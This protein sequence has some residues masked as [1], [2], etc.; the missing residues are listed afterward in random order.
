MP[1]ACDGGSTTIVSEALDRGRVELQL[2]GVGSSGAE[3]RLTRAI[4]VIQGP[5][6]TLFLDTDEDP[7]SA[8][9]DAVVP[10][11]PYSAFLQEGWVLQR[12]GVGGQSEALDA[13]LASSNPV[14]FLVEAGSTTAVPLRFVVGDEAVEVGSF[15]IQLDVEDSSAPSEL[16][17]DDDACGAGET[18]CRG[19][20]LGSCLSLAERE[21]CPLPDLIVSPEVA[22]ASFRLGFETF[23]P[24]SCAIEEGCV[25]A[26]GTRRL[27]RFSTLTANVGAADL[28]MGDPREQP[29]FHFAE[30]HGHFHYEGYAEY[31]LIDAAGQV[32]AAGH[33]QAFCLM[34]TQSVGLP[35]AATRPRFHC[36]LQGLQRGWGDLYNAN[37]DCQWVDV[38]EVPPGNYRLRIAVN[39][40]RII[41]ESNY[42]NNVIEVPVSI[43]DPLAI[44][45]SPEVGPGRECGWS[46]DETLGVVRCTPGEAITIGC[47]GCA[48]GGT[49]EG[50]PV[51]RVCEGAGPCAAFEALASGNDACGLC[52]EAQFVC[53]PSGEF[54]ALTG[55]STAGE[56]FVC[57][58]ST[59][60]MPSTG[61][62]E[63]CN[64]FGEERDCG[65]SLPPEAVQPCTA[66]EA[67]VVGCQGCQT[68]GTCAGDPVMR[69][70]AGT[71]PCTFDAAIATSDDSNCTLCPEV[72]FECPAEGV[73]AVLTGAFVGGD[74]FVC[75]PALGT[76]P[77]PSAF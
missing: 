63:P 56:P 61:P 34:D 8:S 74:P 1:L 68:G 60:S 48:T 16:C 12:L 28:V 27:L 47:Q 10:V 19:G 15:R 51:L 39:P 41:E 4:F 75:E 26:P 53:P 70:C 35:G 52:P 59:S 77:A 76:A 32:A 22:A 67:V 2:V 31:Q 54:S 30:C 49:C 65:W 23:P 24:D 64:L 20:V 9:L 6:S 58:L 69:I 72:A 44:C 11:G 57:Q 37:I 13:R 25:D 42:D 38:T 29:G 55:S 43:G 18:C 73:Y 21:S 33:K 14:A 50:D 40:S 45:S 36:G 5:S 3:Y 7:N 17:S 71:E 62:T 46:A 66:G